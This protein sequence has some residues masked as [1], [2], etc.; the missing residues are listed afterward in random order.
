LPGFL[1]DEVKV[2]EID[3]KPCGLA[4]NKNR[5]ASIHRITEKYSSPEDAAVPEGYRERAF[6]LPFTREPLQEKT[7]KKAPL[8]EEAD[9]EPEGCS[10]KGHPISFSISGVM[11]LFPSHATPIRSSIPSNIRSSVP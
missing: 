5:I 6:L 11:D 9:D 8:A 1:F 2:A 3:Q 7:E 10:V 4:Q